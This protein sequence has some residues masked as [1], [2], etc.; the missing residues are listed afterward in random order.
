MLYRR[1]PGCGMDRRHVGRSKRVYGDGRGSISGAAFGLTHWRQAIGATVT[2]DT[3]RADSGGLLDWLGVE[4]APINSGLWTMP[5]LP[6]TNVHRRVQQWQ[7]ETAAF[8]SSPPPWRTL[9]AGVAASGADRPGRCR[10]QLP[11]RRSLR[12]GAL[13]CILRRTGG[14]GLSDKRQSLES[15][16]AGPNG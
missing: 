4:D 7:A 10:G 11:D 12:A 14:S 8:P 1:T 9:G 6:L 2:L 15:C 3:L 16:G 13:G 5:G